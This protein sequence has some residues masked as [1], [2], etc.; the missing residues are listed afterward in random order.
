MKDNDAPLSPLSVRPFLTGFKLFS[1]IL[2]L[3]VVLWGHAGAGQ[4]I[5]VPEHEFHFVVLGDSQFDNPQTF[6][7]MVEDVSQIRPSF[8]IQVGDLISGYTDDTKQV[9][10]EWQRFKHQLAPLGEIPYFPVPG[11]HDVLGASGE[12]NEEL[13]RIFR[14]TW[15]DLYYSFDYR[16][17]HFLVLDT[18]YQDES[19]RIGPVQFQWLEKDLEENRDKDHIFIFFHRPISSLE[20]QDE[21]HRLFVRFGVRAVFYGHWHHYHYL[22]R[23]GIQYVMTNAAADMGTDIP[24]AGHFHH[25]IL[26]SVRNREFQFAIVKADSIEMP[27]MVAPEDNNDLYRIRNRLLEES[28][29]P[30]GSLVLTEDGYRV[31]FRLNNPTQKDLDVYFQWDL[32]DRRWQVSP[33]R[34]TLVPISAGSRGQTVAFY[35][36]RTDE[37]LPEGWPECRIRIPYLTRDGDWVS[38]E[39]TFRIGEDD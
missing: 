13:E 37:T 26:A 5:D 36:E 25:F 1:G 7:R 9:E 19:E 33:S 12:P 6:N 27:E 14:E 32:P 20:N 30:S 17:A 4:A 39:Q 28:E 3:L 22:E 35:L 24:Q 31:V 34:G 8:V 2:L 23:D 15:G 29:I 10:S 11:N 16:N 21:L 38:V 18:D